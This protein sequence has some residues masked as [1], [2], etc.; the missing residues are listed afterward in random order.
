MTNLNSNMRNVVVLRLLFVMANALGPFAALFLQRHYHFDSSEVA[1]VIT[2]MSVFF[3][4]GNLF[5]G[6]LVKHYSF[7]ILLASSSFCSFVCLLGAMLLGAP[8]A[9]VATVLLFMFFAGLV[10]PVFS[11]L[12]SLAA[13]DSNRIVFFG[14]LHLASN[15]GGA[16][17]FV[18]GGYLLG[19]GSV[20]LIVFATLVSLLCLASSV[21]LRLPTNHHS[22][23]A[24]VESSKGLIVNLPRIVV[25]AGA[26]FFALAVLDAQRE[27]HLP[28]WLTELTAGEA[29]SLF[30]AVGIVNALLV[31]LLTQPLIALT[32]RLG[33]LTNFALA[34]IFYSIGFGAYAIFEHTVLILLFVFFWTLG[35]ILSV[36]YITALI[37]QKVSLTSQAALFSFVPVVLAGA[38]IVSVGLGASLIAGVGFK[39]SWAFYGGLGIV[40]GAIFFWIGA[41][42]KKLSRRSGAEAKGTV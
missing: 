24:T 39:L 36:T 20:Y 21:S 32:S 28:L 41:R 8:V 10:T 11:L 25:L 37:S 13:N 38:R 31:I 1:V 7:R 27:Y 33:P 18:I 40:L 6:V 16:L 19:L 34:A 15:L 4:V 23:D 14:Y 26:M 3:L 22:A 42:S 29:A 2:L 5:G 35:E 17:L 12:T 9:S 30:G